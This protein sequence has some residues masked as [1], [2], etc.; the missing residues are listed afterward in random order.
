[1]S[2]IRIFT[3]RPNHVH[4]SGDPSLENIYS[5]V[6]VTMSCTNQFV[7]DIREIVP[8]LCVLHC[9]IIDIYLITKSYLGHFSTVLDFKVVLR[10]RDLL[11]WRFWKRDLI[12]DCMPLTLGTGSVDLSLALPVCSFTEKNSYFVPH[13]LNVNIEFACF[14]TKMPQE[15]YIK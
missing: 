14:K 13:P 15:V 5:G 11:L 8:E 10:G 12:G 4:C 6:P 9:L 3:A 7:P 2:H 1:M